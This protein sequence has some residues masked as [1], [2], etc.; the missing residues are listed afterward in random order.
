MLAREPLDGI[1]ASQ[2]FSRHGIV[3]PELCAKGVPVPT[4]RPLAEST[5]VGEKMLQALRAGGSWHMVG[6]H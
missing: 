3:I 4:E 1:V 5:E 6:Y 2:P